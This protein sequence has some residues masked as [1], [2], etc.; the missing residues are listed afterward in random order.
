[1]FVCLSAAAWPHYCTDPDV[2]WESGRG[3][4]L[5]VHC[6]ADLKSVHRLRCYDNIAPH[7]LA[8]SAHMTAYR[9][10]R[11]TQ[12]VRDYITCLCSLYAWFSSVCVLCMCFCGAR[13]VTD[14]A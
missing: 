1:M 7:V 4:P 6:R 9:Q 11:Q 12:N 8:V 13:S 10:K 3:C 14:S 5:V 2:S